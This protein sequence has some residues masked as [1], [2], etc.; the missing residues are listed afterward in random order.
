MGLALVIL[1]ACGEPGRVPLGPTSSTDP[2][3]VVD[4]DTDGV[5][6]DP[7]ACVPSRQAFDDNALPVIERSCGT[8]HGAVPDFGA[9]YSLLDYDFLV[10]GPERPVDAMLERLMAGTM[11]PASQGLMPHG[12]R[13]TLVSWA[14]CGL[15][16]PDFSDGV[17]ASRPVWDAP[18]DPP[19]GTT[20]INLSAGEHP[21][22]IDD[23]DDYQYFTFGNLTEEDV[24]IRRMNA[25]IDESRVVHHITLHYLIGYDYL[26]A[27]APGTGAIE[28]ED[29][30]LRLRPSDRLVMEIHYNNG[31]GIPDV[32]DSS[33]I[34]L[35]VDEPGGTE[36]GMASPGVYDIDAAP[37]TVSTATDD[38]RATRDF[39][40]LAGMPHMH[41]IGSELKHVVIRGDGTE[42]TLI[43]L[44]GWSFDSQFFYEQPMEIR[45]GDVLRLSCTF[46]N[47]GA[48]TVQWGEGTEDEM[49]FNFI[50]VT[51]PSAAFQCFVPF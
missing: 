36:W 22:D 28:F 25:V 51:P 1:A 43:E 50:Y 5:P 42:E 6:D 10:T 18:D 15:Q 45:D 29:G 37:G 35:W 4:T 11:P 48:E 3:L 14:S 17:Q 9:P 26:Y 7:P 49:C 31:A 16:H 23:I 21:V 39:T 24:F 40:I 12:D 30:G 46:D 33:G 20:P 44:T 19:E 13:D 38:C 47:P 2:D 8:C 32:R 27:W 34:Q 41:Q